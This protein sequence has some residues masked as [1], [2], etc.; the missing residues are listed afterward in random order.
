MRQDGHHRSVDSQV[1]ASI[2]NVSELARLS[3]YFIAGEMAKSS[4]LPV[5]IG[6]LLKEA[7]GWISIAVIQEQAILLRLGSKDQLHCIQHFLEL[8]NRIRFPS[9]NHL[10]Q[11]ILCS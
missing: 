7:H 5:D 8:T 9:V 2:Q 4:I 1:R 11:S 6:E 3:R 10:V